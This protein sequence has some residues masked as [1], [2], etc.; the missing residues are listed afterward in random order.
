MCIWTFKSSC[1]LDIR[2]FSPSYALTVRDPSNCINQ[3]GRISRILVVWER[4]LMSGVVRDLNDCECNYLFLWLKLVYSCLQ[5][6]RCF[7][8]KFFFKIL[9]PSKV[10]QKQKSKT[11]AV[12]KSN[13]Y[14]IIGL[15]PYEIFF[16]EIHNIV[17][18]K[19]IRIIIKHGKE[20]YVLQC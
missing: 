11:C 6:F 2:S 4:R 20:Q 13:C 12:Q 7:L 17:S 1:I 10:N 5:I 15:S 16:K 19:L 14:F 8:I 18:S 3:R 9:M